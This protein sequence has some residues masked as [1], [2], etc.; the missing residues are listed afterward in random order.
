MNGNLDVHLL[1]GSAAHGARLRHVLLV[2][3]H[4]CRDISA[5]KIDHLLA[6]CVSAV[7]DALSSAA[8]VCDCCKRSFTV[9]WQGRWSVVH[10]AVGRTVNV[11]WQVFLTP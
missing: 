3:D 4:G 11:W 1:P 6:G 10:C 7:G 5:L 8:A 2:A 9:K